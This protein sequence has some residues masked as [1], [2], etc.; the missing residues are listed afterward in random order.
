[1]AEQTKALRLELLK[2]MTAVQ[3]KMTS[4]LASVRTALADKVTKDEAALDSELKTAS[5][6][7]TGVIDSVNADLRQ[8]KTVAQKLDKESKE[9][10]AAQSESEKALSE[11]TGEEMKA[12]GAQMKA[13]DTSMAQARAKLTSQAESIEK[14]LTDKL[15]VQLKHA[16]ATTDAA[17]GKARSEVEDK[18]SA[19]MATVSSKIE[20][21]DA[22]ATAADAAVTAVADEAAACAENG[23]GVTTAWR[24]KARHVFHQPRHGDFKGV[25]HCF[26]AHHVSHGDILRGGDNHCG[27][28]GDQLSNAQ[29]NISRAWREIHHQIIQFTPAHVA[30]K[31]AQCVVEHWAAPNQGRFILD[32]G[33]H[34]NDF[35]AVGAHGDD[36]TI[37]AGLRLFV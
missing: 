26:S 24:C 30:E 4:S 1:M 37:C 5:A 20:G 32:E 8:T 34:G 31:L 13:L 6:T 29:G 2:R 15:D 28:D 23:D 33:A 3:D 10:L 9:Q 17:M 25:E 12:L 11:S 7:A 14:G 19:D 36:F 22:A 18:M 21:T 27:A 35:H 16:A